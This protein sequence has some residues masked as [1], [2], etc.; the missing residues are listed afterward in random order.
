MPFPQFLLQESPWIVETHWWWRGYSWEEPVPRDLSTLG[1]GM[2]VSL[3]LNPPRS[4]LIPSGIVGL[5]LESFLD[6]FFSFFEELCYKEILDFRAKKE[7]E[8]MQTSWWEWIT[9]RQELCFLNYLYHSKRKVAKITAF[10]LQTP[11]KFLS[12]WIYRKLSSTCKTIQLDI[13]L[14]ANLDFIHGK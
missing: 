6:H 10:D 12:H 14:L 13:I 2:K 1:M 3:Y 11:E 5:P 8:A 7:E 9:L 4:P